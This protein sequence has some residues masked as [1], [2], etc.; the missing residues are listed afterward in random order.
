[1]GK[2]VLLKVGN[3]YV[4]SVKITYDDLVIL[5]KQYIDTYNEVPVYSKCDSEHNMPQGRIITR[6]L[7]ENNVTYNDFLLQ[8]GKV[9]HVRTESKDYDLYVKKFKK[10]SNELGH[11]LSGNDLM[12]NEYGLPSQGWFVK[13]CPDKSVKTYDNFVK[14][15]GYESNKLEKD[16]KFVINTLINLEKELGRPILRDD[17]SFEKT[18][19]SMIVL[20]RMFGGLNNAKKEIGLMLTPTDKPLRPFEYYKN[21][22]TEA[23]NNLYEKTGRK[24]LTWHDLES[25]LYHK[26]AIE[27]KTIT[28]A[29]KREG[30]DIFAYIKSLGFEM[31]PNT[32]S[33]KYTFNDGERVV[34]TMEFD[35]ST[36]IRSIGY[37]YNKTYFRDVMYKTFTNSDK[38]R[39]TNCDYCLLLPNDKKLYIEI[40]GVIYNDKNDSWR[41]CD[42]KYKKHTEYQKK[43]LYKENILIENNCNYLFLFPY[44]MKNE[45]YQEILQNKIN[46]ILQEVA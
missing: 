2:A 33:F 25:G 13:Y 46:E 27:H 1:M 26:N 10:I 41:T 7:K 12:N 16:K 23:L 45:K 18:G 44:E 11:A 4:P 35:F 43:M 30:L 38:K 36:Y 14:W 9:S 22:L 6:V 31:N 21:T 34:S 28:Q 3:K 32:F 40:A 5:Y 17:I 29:F 24:F 39:K 8:F 15:C 42:Y 37:E 19:F 20:T